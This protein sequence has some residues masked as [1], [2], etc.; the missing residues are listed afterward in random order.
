M[1]RDAAEDDETKKSILQEPI[2]VASLLLLWLRLSCACVYFAAI[3]VSVEKTTEH[4]RCA[5]SPAHLLTSPDLWPAQAMEKLH[6]AMELVRLAGPVDVR[7]FIEEVTRACCERIYCAGDRG[8][9]QALD[10]THISI[11]T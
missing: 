5:S 3:T 11:H 8:A 6:K 10:L 7:E 9:Y 4:N 1:L 2:K